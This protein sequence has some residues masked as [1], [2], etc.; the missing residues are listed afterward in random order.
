MAQV[1]LQMIL[2]DP[3]EHLDYYNE[4][5]S[6]WTQDSLDPASPIWNKLVEDSH[7]YADDCARGVYD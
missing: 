1:F 3:L 5:M 4:F 6:D 2:D 7:S